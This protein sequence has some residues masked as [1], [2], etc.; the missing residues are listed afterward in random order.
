MKKS[1]MAL[2]L[3][4]AL[5]SVA[6]QAQVQS[7]AQDA[8][9]ERIEVKGHYTVDEKIDTATGLGLTLFETP[10]SV[11]VITAQRI[12]DQALSSIADV[13]GQTVGLAGRQLDSTR[14][15]FSARGFDIDKYQV[16]GVP[17]AWSLAGDSGE[18]ITD[19]AI[20]E[21]IEVVRGATGLLT[22]AGDPSASINLVRKHAHSKTLTGTLAGGIGSW[23]QR[24][25]SADV[26]SGLTTDGAVRARVVLKKEQS[27][28]FR[29]WSEEDKTVLYGVIDADLTDDTLLSVGSSYQHNDPTAS[30][31]GGLASWYSDGSRTDFARETNPAAFWTYWQSTSKNHFVNLQHQFSNGWLLKANYNHVANSAKTKLLYLYG[32]PDKTS[33]TGLNAWPYHSDGFSKQN[34]V[35]MQL[36]GQFQAFG[37]AHDLV[38]GALD[39]RQNAETM[40]FDALPETVAPVGNFFQWNGSYP[41]PA[42]KTSGTLAQDLDTEQ[43]GYYLATRLHLSDQLKLIGG[44][45]LSKWQRSGTSYGSPENYGDNSVWVPYLGLTY[46]LADQHQLYVSQTDIFRPQNAIDKNRQLLEPLEG[47]NRE[48]GLKSQWLDERLQTSFALF[49]V[50]QDNLAQNDGTEPLEGTNT[51]PSKAVDG[52]K[53]RGFELEV[54]GR[55]AQ[56]W[57]ISAGYAQYQAQAPNGDQ[58]NSDYPRKTLQLFTTRRFDGVLAGVDLS[59]FELGGGV[60]WQSENY[61]DTVNSATGKPARLEQGAFALVN[62]MA[63]Y[64][65][66]PALAVQ[67]NVDNLL[68][69]TYYSQIGFFS[70]YGYGEPRN[71]RLT[72]RYQF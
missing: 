3:Q 54:V 10:Q 55:I 31:W 71:A 64:Q 24:F 4:L 1:Q 33:G 52:T 29:D 38:V 66:N 32:A 65:L 69:K 35:D 70:Q 18:T 67:L 62:L 12:D 57:D 2:A 17:L 21:R 39:S 7:Q 11:S 51:I 36:S 37:A 61:T 45:R 48:L 56:G 40:T 8:E 19:V 13:V 34:S 42:W 49:E 46:Q 14:H 58:I 27:D 23:Q 26:G 6:V 59:G 50:R 15:T 22:G 41:E 72:V 25:V 68:D 43:R 30:T 5:W 16:D 9:L 47:Q 53:S 44:G 20:Y 63:R 60:S 28:S